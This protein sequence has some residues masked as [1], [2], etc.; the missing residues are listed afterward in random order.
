MTTSFHCALVRCSVLAILSAS[1]AAQWSP[2]HAGGD[3]RGDATAP[4]PAPDSFAGAL[5]PAS[6]TIPVRD[7]ELLLSAGP[8]ALAGEPFEPRGSGAPSDAVDDEGYYRT[9]YRRFSLSVGGAA[10][11]RFNTDMQ[12]SS[13]T[14]IGAE[15][16]MEKLLGLDDSS[17]VLRLDARYAF[18][19]THWVEFSYYDIER[20]GEKVIS[21]PI[22]VGDVLIPAGQT[23]THFDTAII[24]AAYRYNFVTDPR[25][26]IGASIGLHVMQIDTAVSSPTFAVEEEFRVAAPL[27]LLGIHGSYALS[28]KWRLSAAAEFL[29][30]DLGDYQGLITDTRLTLDHDTTRHVGWGIGF[31]GFQADA[32]VEGDDDL[33]SE[34]Q[35]GYQGVMLYLRLLL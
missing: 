8:E 7:V 25:T 24:K 4:P 16:D 13:S 22:Q 9:L 30:F 11:A 5:E 31:N 21:D 17:T 10:Y 14:A 27:P 26:V 23:T 28:E 18:N 12:I 35:Y 2:V 33:S 20:D 1:G 29:Q 19:R 32:E 6:A 34:L 15:L 3:A